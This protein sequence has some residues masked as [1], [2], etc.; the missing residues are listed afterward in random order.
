MDIVEFLLVAMAVAS[1]LITIFDKFHKWQ[2]YII[3]A[4]FLAS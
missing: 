3:P 4:G 2:K 1:F